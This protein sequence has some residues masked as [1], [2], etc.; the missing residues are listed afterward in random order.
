[1]N[2]TDFRFAYDRTSTDDE[3]IAF[4]CISKDAMGKE[5]NN[6]VFTVRSSPS[7]NW[8]IVSFFACVRHDDS[9][10][11]N[12]YIRFFLFLPFVWTF[13]SFDSLSIRPD[14]TLHRLDYHLF[15]AY[16]VLVAN[17]C[18]FTA[19]RHISKKIIINSSIYAN[20]RRIVWHRLNVRC[21]M[22]NLYLF[23]YG[24]YTRD[25]F[26]HTVRRNG[27]AFLLFFLILNHPIK[28][29]FQWMKWQ[30]ERELKLYQINAR[31]GSEP[32]PKN[33]NE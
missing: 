20:V 26:P 31:F 32:S 33:K 18:S 28:W 11:P 30:I 12:I 10:L 9:Q 21:S 24:A 8:W 5:K 3:S 16:F 25:D 7:M 17:T 27:S 1:M 2:A 14:H 29:H 13:S 23:P 15:N 6:N 22:A 4:K 19:V